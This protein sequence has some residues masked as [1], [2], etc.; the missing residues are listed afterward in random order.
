[1][2]LYPEHDL[3]T[4]LAGVIVLPNP[5]GGANVTLTY[6][7]GGNLMI[8]PVRPVKEGD[9]PQLGVFVMQSGGPPPSP[10]MGQ[11]ESWFV[12]RVQVTVRSDV[13]AYGLGVALARALHARAHLNTP[14]GYT[15]CK[16]GE[17]EP[18]YLGTDEEGAHRWAFNF[19]LGA[20]R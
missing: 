13:N 3:A 16:A 7:A 10:Y 8:G 15:F 11:A 12:S 2:A 6:A 14:A 19:D 18:A 9:V 5:P 20:R 17:A 1:M 4:I